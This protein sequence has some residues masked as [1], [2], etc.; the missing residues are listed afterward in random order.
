M[1][2]VPTPNGALLTI[3]WGNGEQEWTNNLWFRKED[4]TETDM[5]ELVEE[6]GAAASGAYLNELNANWQLKYS[7]CYD[8]RVADGLVVQSVHAPKVGTGT[9]DPLPL[10]LAVVVT[11]RTVRRG[12]SGRGRLYMTGYQEP[13]MTDGRWLPALVTDISNF[14]GTINT[15]AI[16]GGWTWCVRSAQQNGFILPAGFLGPVTYTEVRSSIPGLQRKRSGR[17]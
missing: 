12:R 11:L 14:L 6:P 3:V 9:G 8:M 10:S 15:N 4:F 1:A 5:R 2:F 17:Q 7:R 16:A 13:G